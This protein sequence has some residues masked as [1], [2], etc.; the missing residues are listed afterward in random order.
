MHQPSRF[1][2]WVRV[3]A[4]VIAV[5]VVAVLAP[6]GAVSAGTTGIISGTIT[7]ATTKAPLAGAAVSVASPSSSA[8]TTTNDRGFFSITGLPPDTYTVTITAKG[9]EVLNQA[10]LTVSADQTTTVNQTVSRSLQTIGRTASRS[11]AAAFQPGQTQNTYTVN[12]QQIATIQGNPNNINESNLLTS[13]PGASLDSSGYPVLR[14]GREN[15]EGFQFEGISYTDPITNQFVNSLTI[16]GAQ[17]FQLIPGAGPASQGNNGTGTIN[18]TAKRGTRPAQAQLELETGAVGPEFSQFHAEYGWATP[19]GRL[20]NYTSFVGN[21]GANQ[22]GARGTTA[23]EAN[24]FFN[25]TRSDGRDL[26]NNLVY[27]FGRDNSQSLQV[28]YQNQV[29]DFIENYGGVA[30]YNYVSGDPN[31]GGL[32]PLALGTSDLQSVIGIFPYQGGLNAPARP[33]QITQPNETVKLEYDNNL[34]AS[35][36][37]QA[38]YYKVN[39]DSIFDETFTGIP[40]FGAVNQDLLT[41]GGERTGYRLDLTKQLGSKHLLTLGGRYEYLLP[42]DNSVSYDYGLQVLFGLQSTRGIDFL[43]ASNADC[44]GAGYPCG[45]LLGAN[46]N[47]PGGTPIDYFPGGAVVPPYFRVQSGSRGDYGYYLSDT[48][49]PNANLKVELGARVDGADYHFYPQAIRFASSPTDVL[50]PVGNDYRDPSVLEPRI[51]TTLRLG[52]NDS[53]RASYGISAN[54][55][56]LSFNQRVQNPLVFSSFV[57]I[58]VHG[59]AGAQCGQYFDQ[60]CA[61]YAQEL[62]AIYQHRVGLPYQPTLPE[63]FANWDFSYSH[64][65]PHDISTRIT[66]FYRRGYNQIDRTTVVVGQNPTTGKPILSPTVSTNAGESNTTGVEFLVAKEN[67]SPY[68]FSGQISATYINEF[69]NVIPGTASEDFF[70]TV[71]A[72]SLAAG[73]IYRVGFVSPFQAT[74]SLEYKTRGGLRIVP[75]ITYNRGYPI[76]TGLLTA[77]YIN[78]QAYN[79]PLTDYTG[80]QNGVNYSQFVDPQNPGSL[81]KPNIDATL[82]NGERAS[83]GG[84]LSKANFST[85]LTIEY[86]SPGSKRGT[87]GLQVFNLFDQLYSV[88]FLNTSLQPVATGRLGPQTGF[89]PYYYAQLANQYGLLDT[90]LDAFRYSSYNDYPNNAPRSINLYYR[91]NL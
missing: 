14:G 10:G 20:S 37:L 83:A 38:T 47:G 72:A 11:A 57:G 35:T 45:Y 78:G 24:E 73:N 16:H 13:L 36:F 26:I 27:K 58:P 80:A 43:P 39:S 75:D 69:T 52:G 77:T 42:I 87:I 30:G 76:G 65:F 1:A 21:G 28:F 8:R 61:D 49:S 19:N 89:L 48:Y 18:V 56:P 40:T 54:F 74:A 64:Q 60:P 90:P 85:N 6:F 70:P 46:A 71:P 4:A 88:P 50:Q 84:L 91:L 44:I 41:Q 53:V 25:T 3:M 62:D 32:T 12:A 7:D 86:S 17:S 22:Y 31:L 63:T 79:V 67:R 9:Y 55:A 82:G 2:R 51:A 81:V 15:E 34:N 29:Y 66:P 33:Y 23:A 68:G 59:S 5:A